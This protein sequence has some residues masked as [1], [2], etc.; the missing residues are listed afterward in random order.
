M[1]QG[2]VW[3]ASVVLPASIEER[4]IKMRQT[5]EF[6]RCSISEILRTVLEKGLEAYGY[7]DNRQSETRPA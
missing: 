7:S 5:D 6:A 1:E 2:R 3:R 4:V